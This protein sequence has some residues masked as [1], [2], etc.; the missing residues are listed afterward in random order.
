ML[1]KFVSHNVSVAELGF[2]CGHHPVFLNLEL[3]TI[4]V[5]SLVS[6]RELN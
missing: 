4:A 5:S 3:V 2:C 1:V 6:H